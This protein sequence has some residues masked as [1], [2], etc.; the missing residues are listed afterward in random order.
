ME[1]GEPAQLPPLCLDSNCS[2]GKMLEGNE[3]LLAQLCLDS[4]CSFGKIAYR[5]D[6]FAQQLCLDSNC[7]FGKIQGVVPADERGFALIPIVLSAK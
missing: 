4:N 5:L 1:A 3:K 7:S 2:F 6:D